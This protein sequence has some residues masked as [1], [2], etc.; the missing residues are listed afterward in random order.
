MVQVMGLVQ[1]MVQSSVRDVTATCE[2]DGAPRF[3]LV[4]PAPP[5]IFGG[6]HVTTFARI[7]PGATVTSMTWKV[8]DLMFPFFCRRTRTFCDVLHTLA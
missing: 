7:P 5:V 2:V 8:A 4:P 3:R 1:S 6:Q